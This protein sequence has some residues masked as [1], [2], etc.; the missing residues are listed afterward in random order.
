MEDPLAY[1]KALQLAQECGSFLFIDLVVRREYQKELSK[2]NKLTGLLR[3]IVSG[4][5][6][7][8]LKRFPEFRE[9]TALPATD[10]ATGQNVIRI[11]VTFS[12]RVDVDAYLQRLGMPY[13]FSEIFTN[14]YGDLFSNIDLMD[15]LSSPSKS[16]DDLSAFKF[17]WNMSYRKDIISK[18]LDRLQQCLSCGFTEEQI[19]FRA[20]KL[21]DE[22]YQDEFRKS[23]RVIQQFSGVV[24]FLKDTL[25]RVQSFM[26]GSVTLEYKSVSELVY[27]SNFLS[28]VRNNLSVSLFSD[29]G[30]FVRFSTMLTEEIRLFLVLSYETFQKFL[31]V[32]HTFS[33]IH[34]Y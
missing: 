4:L 7:R 21:H 8:E 29:D 2:I 15:I 31:E 18:V 23:E 27:K 10:A 20:S 6:E 16:F 28:I 9:I 17:A 34:I 30:A 26:L 33:R 1:R 11:V 22:E 5:I 19:K 3:K 12:K 13:T 14:F 24:K 25:R 32:I